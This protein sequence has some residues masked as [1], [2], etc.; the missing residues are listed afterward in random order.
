MK[1][2]LKKIE[3][4][5]NEVIIKYLERNRQIERIIEC[6][7][8]QT[9]KIVATNEEKSFL[10]APKDVIYLESVDGVTY[11]YTAQEVYRTG[12]TLAEAEGMYE[13]EG[14]FRCSK[15]MVINLYQI[16]TLK[17]QPGNRI[18]ATMDNGEHVI[19]SR[20][21]AKQFRA[22]LKGGWSRE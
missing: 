19:I 5:E 13:E 22:A 8:G 7:K 18:D 1:L 6:V 21:Y 2:I 17:S 4:G 14:F 15:S 3:A 9:N 16:H 11:L 12:L 20:R 10:V